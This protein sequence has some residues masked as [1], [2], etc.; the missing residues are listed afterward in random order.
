MADPGQHLGALVQLAH[1]P[2]AHRLKG[3]AGKPDLARA[4]EP[5]ILCLPPQ[6]ERAC[7]VGE[8]QDRLDLSAHEQQRHRKQQDR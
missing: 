1:D 3:A 6:P 2:V 5:V 7:R 4:F 8:P